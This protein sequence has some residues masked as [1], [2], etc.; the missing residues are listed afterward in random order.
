LVLKKYNG[1]GGSGTYFLSTADLAKAELCSF[2]QMHGYDLAESYIVQHEDMNRLSPSGVNTVRI[3]TQLDHK[4][5]VILLGCRQRISVN[6][7]VDNLAAGNIAASIDC[8]T[9]I[10]DGPGVYSDITKED[11]YAHPVTNVT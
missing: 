4:N 8:E 7:P 11:V 10:I 1:K 5:E 3:F 9:G 6:S 2:M